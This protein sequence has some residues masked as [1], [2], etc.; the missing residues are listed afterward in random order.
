MR[1]TEER[2]PAQLEPVVSVACIHTPDKLMRPLVVVDGGGC[3]GLFVTNF[4]QTLVGDHTCSMMHI[5]Q[6]WLSFHYYIMK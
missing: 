6:Y 2:I 3:L 4:F 5:D 1:F